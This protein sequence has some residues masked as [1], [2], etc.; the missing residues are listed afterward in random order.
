[1]L[2]GHQSLRCF[3]YPSIPV[4]FERGSKS[5]TYG[6]TKSAPIM[7]ESA[8]DEKHENYGDIRA[9]E[10]ILFAVYTRPR[11]SGLREQA[12]LKVKSILKGTDYEC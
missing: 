6:N 1:M 12:A 2:F 5:R 8:S 7:H 4:I 9:R 11:F 3:R 10:S